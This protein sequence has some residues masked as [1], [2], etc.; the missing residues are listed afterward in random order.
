MGLVHCLRPRRAVQVHP[1]G[2]A[3]AEALNSLYEAELIRN[4]GPCCEDID[5]ACARHRRVGPLGG[6]YSATLRLRHASPHRARSYLDPV[7]TA[8]AA[9]TTTTSNHRHQT[10]QPPQ[11]P[12]L[13]R[14]YC[15]GLLGVFRTVLVLCFRLPSSGPGNRV[16]PRS[17]CDTLGLREGGH[18]CISAR[19]TRQCP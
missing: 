15:C 1:Y 13:D 2:A 6:Y 10:N 17:G 9:G 12:G 11:N 3:L 19:S 16:R 14:L 8:T 5:A 7:T 18:D 4:Q